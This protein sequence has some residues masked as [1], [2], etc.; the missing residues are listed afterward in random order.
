MEYYK[1]I[2]INLDRAKER[3]YKIDNQLKLQNIDYIRYSAFDGK[4]I[5]NKSI[6]CNISNKNFYGYPRELKMGEIGCTLSHIGAISM[7]KSLNL[8]YVII[9]EDDIILCNDFKERLDILFKSVPK[10][11]EHIF[12]GGHVYNFEPLCIPGIYKSPKVSGTYSYIL[13]NTGYDKAINALTSMETTTDDLYEHSKLIS[14]IYFP[15]FTYPLLEYSF[16]NEV[17]GRSC[18]HPSKKWFRE[19]L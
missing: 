9:L 3:L 1:I 11:W 12:L 6:K 2:L 18:T 7:A 5:L 4:N 14:Y 17:D 16:V 13:R 10:N 15:L 19:K 8:E